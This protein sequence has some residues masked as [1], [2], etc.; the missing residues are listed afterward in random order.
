[1]N[2][3]VNKQ[4]NGTMKV[5]SM[6]LP[7][8]HRVKENDEWWGE[9]FT[10]WVAVRQAKP[11]F[12]GHYQPHIPMNKNYYDLL[13]KGTMEWQARLMKQYGID[14][15]C[16]YHYWFKDGRKILEKPAENLLNWTDID[17]PF[18]FC[19]ANESWART[20]T[21]L[22]NYT[23]WSSELEPKRNEENDDGIL[24]DQ[25]YGS[26]KQWK[27]HFE[28][29]LPFFKDKRYIKIENKPIFMIFKTAEIYC[30]KEM[31]ILWK[32]WAK[33]EGFSGIYLVG[34]DVEYE[35]EVLD[36][37]IS[38]EPNNAMR[39]KIDYNKRNTGISKYT[40]REI[41]KEIL[42][43]PINGRKKTIQGT[44]GRDNTPRM[45][46]RGEVIV[47]ANPYE[48]REYMSELLA[49]NK[50]NG[51]D[52]TFVNAWNEW[53]EG[54]HLEPD[55][56]FKYKFLEGILYAKNNYKKY[57]QKYSK[58]FISEN[59][60]KEIESLTLANQRYRSYWRILDIWLT[61]KEKGI[62]LSDL[63]Q[64]KGISSVAIYGI[65]LLGKHLYYELKNSKIEVKFVIDRSRSIGE[66]NLSLYRPE[67][68]LPEVD[69]IVIT[70]TYAYSEI[71]AQ[72]AA[73]G[74]ENVISLEW[75]VNEWTQ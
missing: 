49:K 13:N 28:Y 14:G 50:S 58:A 46:R 21:K 59:V 32:E 39:K 9:G 5:I 1:M 19:W 33:K 42:E 10:E 37:E 55:E 30:L 4:R 34:G 45:G 20:W 63:F 67:D 38:F 64:K 47:D 75:V 25:K 43:Y 65:G 73:R 8:F 44:V 41:W 54:M 17:M 68:E 6:Y 31:M 56:K 2:K 26:E 51:C 35:A 53:G 66:S 3:R 27:Q 16:I 18:C 7:Q 60:K 24:I 36:M 71:S 57:I 40:Y 23:P 72:L 12:D 70:P 48:F 52:I 69:I 15:Q 11:L 22:Q 62:E 61:L 29:L 74:Y